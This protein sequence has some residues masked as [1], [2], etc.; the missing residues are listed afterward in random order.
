[1]SD[2]ADTPK[3]RVAFHSPIESTSI[4][5]AIARSTS[6]LATPSRLSKSL[7]RKCHV[8]CWF[9]LYRCAFW[10]LPA[11]NPSSSRNLQ[12]RRPLGVLTSQTSMPLWPQAAIALWPFNTCAIYR[13]SNAH[14]HEQIML[15]LLYTIWPP[16][17]EVNIV[18]MAQNEDGANFK[19]FL[20]LNINACPYPCQKITHFTT[21]M[22]R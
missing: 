13:M 5:R 1:M 21:N 20:D 10:G 15:H 14:G 3:I 11:F 16:Q 12:P 9:M 18:W 19:L 22:K 2:S 17:K 6:L 7:W 4:S 8:S